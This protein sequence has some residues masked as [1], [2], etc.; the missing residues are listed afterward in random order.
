MVGKARIRPK[1]ASS[2]P[3]L[4]VGLVVAGVTLTTAACRPS[5]SDEGDLVI[6]LSVSPTPPATG[7]A[8]LT[9]MV[10]ERTGAPVERA[11]VQVQGT[12]SHPGMPTT[13]VSARDEGGG[14][15]VVDAFD[16]SMA[17]DWILTVSVGL[18]DRRSA[19]RDFP[20][21]AIGAPSPEDPGT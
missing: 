2:V 7:P 1:P 19:Q 14:R 13:T 15:F 8:R 5:A 21:R 18:P 17:G 6:D 16:F 12:M 9:I 20:L 11:L 10:T 4:V 3:A